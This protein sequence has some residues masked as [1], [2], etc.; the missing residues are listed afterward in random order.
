METRTGSFRLW[1]LLVAALVYIGYGYGCAI[2]HIPRDYHTPFR[3]R[4]WLCSTAQYVQANVCLAFF[5]PATGSIFQPA[6]TIT[7]LIASAKSFPRKLQARHLWLLYPM[8]TLLA[9]SMWDAYC[10]PFSATPPWTRYHWQADIL[11]DIFLISAA[12]YIL[13]YAL[14]M[15]SKTWKEERGFATYI[16]L[17]FLIN[18]FLFFLWQIMFVSNSW[19]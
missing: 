18:G 19:L 9:V 5:N 16:F 4:D 11:R 14:I 15:K 17:W 3:F 2:S 1:L 7:L 6:I 8:T 12:P 10:F 13:A